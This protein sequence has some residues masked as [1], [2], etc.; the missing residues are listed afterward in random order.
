MLRM[1]YEYEMPAADPAPTPAAVRLRELIRFN[2]WIAPPSVPVL[3]A[4]WWVWRTPPLLIIAGLVA[5]TII[6]QRV[7]VYYTARNEI[8]RGITALVIAIW[9]PT[10]GLAVLAPEVW[11]ITAVL[12][13]LSV[14]LAVPFVEPRRVLGLI[15]VASAILLVGGWFRVAP[16]FH[17]TPPEASPL[18]ISC[19]VTAGSGVGAMLCMFSVWQSNSRLVDTIERLSRSE[20][21]LEQKVEERTRQIRHDLEA[22]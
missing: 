16:W 6:V 8:D 18:M 12:A 3:L 4:F 19:I 11:A 15:G 1:P 14:L 17:S 7:A 10:A 2:Q 13:V 21:E 5:A 22:A 9:L 20:R